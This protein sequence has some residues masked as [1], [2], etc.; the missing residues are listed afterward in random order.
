MFPGYSFTYLHNFS[1]KLCRCVPGKCFIGCWKKQV[2]IHKLGGG[3]VSWGRQI[4]LWENLVSC[5]GDLRFLG[6][7]ACRSLAPAR[8]ER[9]N[10]YG[11]FSE[12]LLEFSNTCMMSNIHSY[13]TTKI[14]KKTS[15]LIWNKR[16]HPIWTFREF[17]KQV[18]LL[19][20]V[21]WRSTLA[22]GG[23]VLW[24]QWLLILWPLGRDHLFV[25]FS[26]S[27]LLVLPLANLIMPFFVISIGQKFRHLC[28]LCFIWSFR[29]EK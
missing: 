25:F 17:I 8:C 24:D 6:C 7:F 13:D 23:V 20:L 15:S 2:K 22:N 28:F 12:H 3:G 16:I 27:V 11:F 4:C 1:K 19:W 26:Q 21:C 9:V 5:V 18:P 14:N 10:R 29:P